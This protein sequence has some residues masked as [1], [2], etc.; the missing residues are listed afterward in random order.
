MQFIRTYAPIVV[1]ILM[2]AF[3][4]ALC[5]DEYVDQKRAAQDMLI[6]VC[7]E[8]EA[9]DYEWDEADEFIGI[10]RTNLT[11]TLSPREGEMSL[12]MSRIHSNAYQTE[13]QKRGL[14]RRYAPRKALQS[15][16]YIL[17]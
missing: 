3:V 14:V 11:L 10:G 6:E 15:Y 9:D 17:T 5:M 8:I 12:L 7:A 2:S 13:E 1:L 16:N 4:M